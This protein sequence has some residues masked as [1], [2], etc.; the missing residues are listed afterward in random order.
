MRILPWVLG[1]SGVAACTSVLGGFDF[2]G[3]SASGN[4][5]TGGGAGGE[6][7]AN[8]S[9]C[10]ADDECLDLHCVD[11][12]CCDSA[13]D[14]ACEAC[15]SDGTCGTAEAG[16]VQISAGQYH[17]CALKADGSVWCWGRNDFGQ[18]GHSGTGGGADS[19]TPILVDSFL[20]PDDQVAE[21]ALGGDRTC[22]RST[23]GAVRCWGSLVTIDGGDG[24]GSPDASA[25]QSLAATAVEL[26]VGDYHGCARLATGSVYCW[27]GNEYGQL[28]QGGNVP[29]TKAEH[30]DLPMLQDVTQITAG[31]Y[32]SC[33]RDANGS[34]YC[35]G[36][37]GHGQLGTGS[38]L[39]DL[40]AP[41]E[42]LADELSEAIDVSAGRRHTC[43][44]HPNGTV[45]CWGYNSKGQLGDGTIAERHEPTSVNV[46]GMDAAEVTLGNGHTCARSK[47][48]AVWCWGANDQGQ[49]GGALDGGTL[50][51]TPLVVT[52]LPPSVVEI[53]AGGSH[54]CARSID[55]TI[56]CWGAN[57][58]GQLGNG[59]T[60][61]ASKPVQVHLSCP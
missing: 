44:V 28:G 60:A 54:T 9:L 33:A 8:G 32:H 38:V 42:V 30:V 46:V 27:G 12:V 40:S 3:P 4:S 51:S 56:W 19:L 37:D 13:C 22:A 58:H 55:G 43:A 39:G 47:G 2:N 49:L 29:S 35:W 6:A 10:G 50:S 26:D 11:G 5:G 57:G 61:E 18:L 7:L 34:L 52:E 45:Y 1:L 20:P 17:T 53:S 59:I 15:G 41:V 25:V 36:N 31:R 16:A 48:G 21:I 24:G 14:G 23:K